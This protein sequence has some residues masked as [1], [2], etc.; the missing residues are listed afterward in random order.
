MKFFYLVSTLFAVGGLP[1]AVDSSADADVA[2]TFTSVAERF[3]LWAAV[4]VALMVALI[5]TGWLRERRMAKRIDDLEKDLVLLAKAATSAQRD[6]QGS[7]AAQTKVL[8]TLSTQTKEQTDVLK[9]IKIVFSQKICPF[10]GG[11]RP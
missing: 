3:G 8:E 10:E 1:L 6:V 2:N 4:T 7:I 9:E 5:V 11:R